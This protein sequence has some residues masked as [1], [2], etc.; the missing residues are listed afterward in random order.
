MKTCRLKSSWRALVGMPTCKCSWWNQRSSGIQ[1]LECSSIKFPMSWSSQRLSSIVSF[2]RSS[3]TKSSALTC[4]GKWTSRRFPNYLAPSCPSPSL[5]KKTLILSALRRS[6]WLSAVRTVWC[7]LEVAMWQSKSITTAT[8]R[9]SVSNFT[10]KCQITI[11]LLKTPWSHCSNTIRPTPSSSQNII[12]LTMTNGRPAIS[13]S[14]Y[15]R[16]SLKTSRKSSI[17]KVI[18]RR[19]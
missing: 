6:K 9:S 16:P 19:V 12:K 11:R 2:I 4:L 14:W 1:S 8:R 5:K 15:S 18:E 10:R 17:R 13:S 3:E 7:A